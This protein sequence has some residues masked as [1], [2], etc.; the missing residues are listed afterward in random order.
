MMTASQNFNVEIL[1]PCTDDSLTIAVA[2]FMTN[3]PLMTYYIG[4]AAM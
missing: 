4:D 3:D 2:H 1:R